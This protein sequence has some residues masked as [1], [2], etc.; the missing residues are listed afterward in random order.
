MNLNGAHGSS[1]GMGKDLMSLFRVS[2][3]PAGDGDCLVL[4]WGEPGALGHAVIDGGRAATYAAL[5]RRLLEMAKAGER[6]E[7]FILT[8]VDADHIEGGLKFV[9]DGERPIAPGRVWYNSFDAL[10]GLRARSIA[11]G[12]RYAAAIRNLGWPLNGGFEHELVSVATAP[13]GLGVPGLR[14]TVLGPDGDGV[15]A[16][17]SKWADWRL[18]HDP[19]LLART[20]RLSRAPMPSRLDV[21]ALALPGK[22][23]TELPNGSSISILAE[24]GG[25]RVLLAGDAHPDTLVRAI[26]PLAKAEGGRLRVDLFK[27]PH[28]GSRGNVT[29]EL[30]ELLDCRRFAI[31]TDGTRHGHPDPEAISRLLAFAPPGRRQLFFNYASERTLPWDDADLQKTWDYECFYGDPQGTLE[32]DV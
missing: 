16:M 21:A 22:T 32:M 19:V 29:R 3:L 31:S 18:D 20:G 10:G 25:R 14:V 13:A 28:H 1:A 27:V 12:D 9:E 5:R 17:R 2:M 6:L 26:A 7:L 30:I 11:Q 4:S 15:E 8:H 24:H 23:D